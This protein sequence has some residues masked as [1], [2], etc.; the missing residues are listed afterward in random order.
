MAKQLKIARLDE[1][2]VAHLRE[3]EQALDKH[4][5]AF[6]PGLEFAALS[7]DDMARVEAL[8]KDLG[9]ILLVYGT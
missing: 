5:M 8:E 2:A 3:L 9:V 1:T 6:E 7:E 4:I